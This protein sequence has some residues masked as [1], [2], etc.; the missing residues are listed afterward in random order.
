MK[1]LKIEK[2][3]AEWRQRMTRFIE[4]HTTEYKRQLT[5][6]LEK[7]VVAFLN[8]GDGGEI[9]IGIDT[10]TDSTVAID[11]IDSIQLKIKD[12]LKNNIEPSIMGLFDV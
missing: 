2:T 11:D 10:K 5:D 7:E 12:R 4:T 8:S 9:F 3:Q 6:G 1:C